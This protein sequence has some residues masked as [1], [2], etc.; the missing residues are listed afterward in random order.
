MIESHRQRRLVFNRLDRLNMEQGDMLRLITLGETI[1]ESHYF[2]GKGL[3]N[4]ATSTT[5]Q[6]PF[7]DRSGHPFG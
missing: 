6:R 1:V 5:V 3:G 2:L 4:V 7:N